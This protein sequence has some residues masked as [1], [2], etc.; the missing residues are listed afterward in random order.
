MVATIAYMDDRKMAQSIAKEKDTKLLDERLL[1]RFASRAL[2]PKN[3]V[4][5]VALA[6]AERIVRA[7]ARISSE[8][9]I[10]QQAHEKIDEQLQYVPLTKP[11]L[12][13]V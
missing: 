9:P 8:L 11:F 4:L 13:N 5:E 7:W 2:V 1:E 12:H 6:T 10:S 3:L